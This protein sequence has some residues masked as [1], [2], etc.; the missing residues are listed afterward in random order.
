MT[1]DEVCSDCMWRNRCLVLM[2]MGYG[3]HISSCMG[4]RCAP[5]TT[6]MNM[7]FPVSIAM[8]AT[9]SDPDFHDA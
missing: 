7:T 8:T 6:V 4:R 1:L 2:A 5:T 3:D 9:T